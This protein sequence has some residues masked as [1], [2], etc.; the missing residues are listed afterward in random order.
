M[1]AATTI[2]AEII[3][4]VRAEKEGKKGLICGP[5]AATTLEKV[6]DIP[7]TALRF[8]EG[9]LD[10]FNKKAH[11]EN[12]ISRTDV[13]VMSKRGKEIRILFVYRGLS[14]FISRDLNLLKR[15]FDVRHV[16]LRAYRRN[17]LILFKLIKGVLWA[18]MVFSWFAETNA[19]FIV[20]FS[21]I[22]RKKSVIVA[23][24]Y[25]VANVPEIGYG[26]LLN[27]ISAQRAKIVLEHADKI[28]PFSKFAME[29]VLNI[30]KKA[31]IDMIPLACD[32]EKFKAGKRKKENIVLTV[33]VVKDGNIARKGLETFLESARLLPEVKFILVGPHKDDSINYLRKVSPSNVEFTGYV[34]EKELIGWYQRAK[35]YCQLSYQEGE[36]AGGALGEAMACECIP[37]V[38]L[39]AVAL[40]ETV[41]DCGFYVPYGDAEAT[42]KAIKS[43]LHSSSE[44]GARARKC[45]KD[46]F[47]MDKREH[48]LLK[49]ISACIR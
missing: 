9:P 27:P 40:R 29:E 16:S 2:D 22:F 30:T 35:V 24:G 43:A 46:L 10:Q 33:C 45:V 36:G 8:E 49:S 38:S 37:V 4:G 25:G 11:R 26:A 23:G 19:F 42:A 48:A 28:L 14:T 3:H 15:H 1:R 21:K 31:H 39:K 6:V 34:S 18:D 44:L 7:I 5:I 47:P 13:S 20:L 41:G 32:T 12:L 17:P